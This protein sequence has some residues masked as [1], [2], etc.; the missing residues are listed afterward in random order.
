[1]MMRHFARPF[2]V[3]E[4]EI[5]LTLSIGI[6]IYPDDGDDIDTLITQADQAMYRVRARTRERTDVPSALRAGRSAVSEAR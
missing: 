2:A 4:H 1:M 5:S 6:S 3:G